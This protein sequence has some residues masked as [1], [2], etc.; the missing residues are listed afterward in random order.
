MTSVS[1][2]WIAD[3]STHLLSA[4]SGAKSAEYGIDKTKLIGYLINIAD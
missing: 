4:F 2:L 3:P 1:A